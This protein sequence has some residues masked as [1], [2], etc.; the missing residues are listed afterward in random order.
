MRRCRHQRRRLVRARDHSH[1]VIV[2][3][4]TVHRSTEQVVRLAYVLLGPMVGDG[5]IPM[6]KVLDRAEPQEKAG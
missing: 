3:E 2:C 4:K 1:V 5:A 6:M